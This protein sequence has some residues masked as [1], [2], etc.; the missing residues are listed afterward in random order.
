MYRSIRSYE[1]TRRSNFYL[2]IKP[3]KAQKLLPL[4]TITKI[5]YKSIPC[6]VKNGPRPS[7]QF[8]AVMH[9]NIF[10]SAACADDVTWYIGFHRHAIL[11]IMFALL[12][13]IKKFLV[14][15]LFLEKKYKHVLKVWILQITLVAWTELL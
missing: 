2:R 11:F 12:Y 4:E 3:I 9:L 14:F 10:A 15:H 6:T 1:A 8:L 7:S 13:F 5:R